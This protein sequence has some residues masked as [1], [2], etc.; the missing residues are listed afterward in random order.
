MHWQ[1]LLSAEA[2]PRLTSLLALAPLLG[3]WG[4]VAGRLDAFLG[5]CSRFFR[6]A[7]LCL[8][9]RLVVAERVVVLKD[10]AFRLGL[11]LCELLCITPSHVSCL[12]ESRKSNVV[13]HCYMK[14]FI[15]SNCCARCPGKQ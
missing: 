2:V 1:V 8:W 6:L 15:C 14:E 3:W 12:A 4:N 13:M 7:G 9:R 11:L 10:V 5:L